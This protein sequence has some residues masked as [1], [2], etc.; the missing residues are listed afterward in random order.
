MDKQNIIKSWLAEFEE[1]STSWNTRILLALVCDCWNHKTT[2]LNNDLCYSFDFVSMY[3]E[4]PYLFFCII[5]HHKDI[6]NKYKYNSKCTVADMRFVERAENNINYIKKQMTNTQWSCKNHDM[7]TELFFEE[8][9]DSIRKPLLSISRGNS[10]LHKI[11]LID[12]LAIM[13]HN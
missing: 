2:L 6:I 12:A 11:I 1:D 10:L 4:E 9:T 5:Q 13:K 8:T 3:N 7:F